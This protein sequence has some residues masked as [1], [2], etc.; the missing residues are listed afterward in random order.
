MHTSL[1]YHSSRK[2]SVNDLVSYL[3]RMVRLPGRAVSQQQMSV[4]P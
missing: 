3:V 4:D 2:G 1:G